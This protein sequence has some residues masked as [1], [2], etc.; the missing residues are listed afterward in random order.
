MVGYGIWR[1][2]FWVSAQKSNNLGQEVKSIK[3]EEALNGI[4][5]V[6]KREKEIKAS[7]L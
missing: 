5:V 6:D 4:I 1:E 7:Q 2:S 3:V